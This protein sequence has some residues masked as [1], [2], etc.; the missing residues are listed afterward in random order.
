MEDEAVLN[1]LVHRTMAGKEREHSSGMRKSLADM[2]S[3]RL[4]ELRLKMHE[5]L[6]MAPTFKCD[7][8]MVTDTGR[9]VSGHDDR[10]FLAF[11]GEGL[12]QRG[13]NNNGWAEKSSRLR[14]A[15]LRVRP[16][17]RDSSALLGDTTRPL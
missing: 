14:C 5:Q 2:R 7:G 17:G 16:I 12:L 11:G 4:G 8:D 1:M 10:S 3:L 13:N 6:T 15:P 9:R